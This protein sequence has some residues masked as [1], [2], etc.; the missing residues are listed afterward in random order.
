MLRNPRDLTQASPDANVETTIGVGRGV[1]GEIAGRPPPELTAAS[2]DSSIPPDM[3][4][5]PLGK[6]RWSD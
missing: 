5:K 6:V 3:N 1:A 4:Q 2:R